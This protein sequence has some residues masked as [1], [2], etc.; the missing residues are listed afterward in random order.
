MD[1]IDQRIADEFNKVSGQRD[2][3]QN[4]L[5]GRIAYT[6]LDQ[7]LEFSLL[8]AYVFERSDLYLAPRVSYDYADGVRITLGGNIYEG[9]DQ[10]STF[11]MFDN[12][13]NI[14]LE[15]RYSF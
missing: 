8:G 3:L 9:G 13:D 6:L 10:F 5:L 11:G 15:V 12:Y 14:F 2:A 1:P 7:T 4:A